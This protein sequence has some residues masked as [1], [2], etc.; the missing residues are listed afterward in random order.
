MLESLKATSAQH[1]AHASVILGRVTELDKT[2]R[3]LLNAKSRYKAVGDPLG[4]PW[5]FIACVHKRESD[6]NWMA[7]LAQGD[8]WNRVSTHVPKGRGPFHNWEEAAIDALKLDGVDDW[9]DWSIGGTLAAWERYNG[10]GYYHKGRVSPYVWGATDQYLKGKYVADGHFDGDAVDRQPGCAALLARLML[11]DASIQAH[12]H[13]QL[14]FNPG[15]VGPAP[16]DY[17]NLDIQIGLNKLGAHPRLVED[18][19]VG[20]A[21]IAAIRQFQEREGLQS[22]GKFGPQSAAAFKRALEQLGA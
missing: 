10:L 6:V 11:L 2:A 14:S 8:P 13:W 16:A 4:I 15:D 3:V 22:D 21:T 9:D 19:L 12:Y 20:R 1:W 18:G 5:P 7:S 17:S